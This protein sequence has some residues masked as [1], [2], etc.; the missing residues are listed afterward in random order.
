MNAKTKLD[1]AIQ[2][3]D[4]LLPPAIKK[5]KNVQLLFLFVCVCVECISLVLSSEEK[6]ENVCKIKKKK[7]FSSHGITH[8]ETKMAKHA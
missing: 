6:E 4:K 3:L 8:D 5:K 7:L 1:N 2:S